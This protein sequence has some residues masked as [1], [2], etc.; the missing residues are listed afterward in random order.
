MKLISHRG[1]ING[2]IED[3]ENNPDYLDIALSKGFDVEIDIW[4][5]NNI[6]F[7]GHDEPKYKIDF[8]WL[9][10]RLDKLWV[11][12]KNIDALMYF[13]KSV[14]PINYFWHQQDDVTITSQGFFWTFPGKQLTKNSI[15]VMPEIKNFYDINISYGVCSDVIEKYKNDNK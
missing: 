9:V 12:C 6:L 4:C 10:D 1:N 14:Q 5:N 15:A 2:P 8:M 7:L 11:H 3:L 13:K